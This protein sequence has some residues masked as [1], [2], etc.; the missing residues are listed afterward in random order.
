MEWQFFTNNPDSAREL[1]EFLGVSPLVAQLLL[2][3]GLGQ[4]EAAQAF[5]NPT[6]SG[7]SSPTLMKDMDRA[8]ARIIQ[9]IRGQEKIAVY[10]DYD[11]DGLTATAVLV[12]FLRPFLPDILYYIPHRT[13]EGYGLNQ[14]SLSRLREQGATLVITVDCGSSNHGEIEW[15]KGQGM[16]VLV[17]DHH[18]VGLQGVPR[19]AAVVNPKQEGCRFPFKELAG[20]G[21]AFNLVIAL[22]Q[23]LEAEGF[24][25]G[26]KPNLRSY[27][28][29]VVLGTVAD[30]VPLTGDNRIYA[31][32]GLRVLNDSTREGI[33]ALKAVSGIL[34]AA[35][36]SAVDVAFRL[37]PRLNALGRLTEAKEGIE[38]L[39]TGGRERARLLAE[40]MDQENRRRQEIEQQL[41]KEIDETI[42]AD[43]GLYQRKCLVL[44]SE[45][46]PRG[47]LGLIASRLVERWFRPVFLFA[48][49]DGLAQGSG[50][51]IGGFHLFKALEE[52]APRLLRFG[53]HAA[54][55]G[56]A[57]KVED[58]P[59][60]EQALEALVEKTL[61]PESFI[62]SL[63]VEAEV[64]FSLLGKSL[65]PYLPRLAP[66]GQGN[67][68][69]ILVT[70]QARVKTLRPV[71]NGHLRMTLENKGITL[72]GFG[73]NLGELPLAPGES[74]DLAYTTDIEKRG[75]NAHLQLRIKD[76]KKTER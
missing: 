70:R 34:P 64:D 67:P 17:T 42:S 57:L 74:V 58:L 37:A 47:I 12:T 45:K 10:G 36:I 44:W 40:I 4:P 7:L 62:P 68:E 21:V 75:P 6:L 38:L 29:L 2:H 61:P 23:A 26:P 66:F 13:R 63:R 41:L 76:I 35:R 52:L 56:A 9:A 49:E 72:D 25:S 71:G 16:E 3:R 11:A 22:R 32:D 30:M 15:A 73:F 65:V 53:G 31:A 69:P 54:A 51:S 1:A 24:F 27:L 46:W 5:L 14:G 50:R 33:L 48:L 28:D 60:F 19:A 39:I 43:P 59:F 18:Q 20:V 55:A 8:V